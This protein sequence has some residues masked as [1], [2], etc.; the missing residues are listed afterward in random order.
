M[1]TIVNGLGEDGKASPVA[2]RGNIPKPDDALLPIRCVLA[3]KLKELR[4]VLVIQKRKARYYGPSLLH[5]SGRR[6][7]MKGLDEA[8][9]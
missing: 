7:R 9:T 6:V 2:V 1:L 4:A 5:D 3:D 8:R